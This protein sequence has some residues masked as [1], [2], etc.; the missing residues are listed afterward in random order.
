MTDK[1]ELVTGPG[2]SRVAGLRLLAMK[3]ALVAACT[4]LLILAAPMAGLSSAS[5]AERGTPDEAIAMVKRVQDSVRQKGLRATLAAIT[6]QEPQ[7]KDRDLYAFVITFDGVVVAH[8]V[9]PVLVGKYVLDLR[10]TDNNPFI[11][12][13]LDV[14]K[15]GRPGWVDYK[16][17]NP[18][19]NT[20]AQKTS[21]VEKLGNNYFVAVGVYKGELSR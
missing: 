2:L 1:N 20:I 17:P 4:C 12:G 3:R 9:L 16:W 11:R 8:G 14:A 13:F 15:S 19:N 7:F 21:Y 18:T 5:A 10:D 6:A